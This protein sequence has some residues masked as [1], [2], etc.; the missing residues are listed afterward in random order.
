MSQSNQEFYAT[1][2]MNEQQLN[3]AR[4]ALYSYCKVMRVP[5]LGVV[6]VLVTFLT[7]M[8]ITLVLAALGES[9]WTAMAIGAPVS[10]L[11]AF[12]CWLLYRYRV[13]A[14]KRLNT[15]LAADGGKGMI[16]D[17][18]SARPFVDDQFRVGRYYLFIKNGAVI[19]LDG[20][21]D[22]VRVTSHYKAVPLL[23][24]LSVKVKD[25]NGSMACPLCRVHLLKAEAE[26]D[27]IRRALMQRHLS[28]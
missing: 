7:G 4:Q 19:R 1:G 11:F 2:I 5:K 24:Q 8:F 10:A 27:E 20:I 14:S 28:V 3:Q 17:F 9:I 22:I 16:I 12:L 13:A 25:E 18:A 26:I 23:V 21:I 6:P 15:Y